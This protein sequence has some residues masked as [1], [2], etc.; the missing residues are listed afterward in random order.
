LGGVILRYATAQPLTIL[1]SA[2]ETHYFFF[3]V[4]GVRPEYA[5]ETV[6]L[7]GLAGETG[8]SLSLA[9][10]LLIRPQPGLERS[11]SFTTPDGRGVRITTLA[12]HEAEH[13]WQGSAWNAERLVISEADVFFAEGGVDLRTEEPETTLAVFPALQALPQP[14][15]LAVTRMNSPAGAAFS[16][17]HLA[18]AAHSPAFHLEPCSEHKYLLSFPP[19][20]LEG[21]EDAFLHIE[22]AGDTCGAFINGRL[23][24]D[25]YNNGTPW[26]I[27][28]KRFLPELLAHGLLL[29]FRPLSRGTVKNISSPMASRAVFEGEQL[30][31]LKDIRLL[32][33]YALRLVD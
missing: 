20:L 22:Y 24:A 3:A 13:A 27:G 1:Q 16:S 6:G 7:P 11:F 19:D 18:A 15:G 2:E 26:R 33:E 21:L 25:N 32:P 12:R 9:Q 4:E 23:V 8:E 29:K 10:G 5:F 30:F 14:R 17:F 31:K 28:L